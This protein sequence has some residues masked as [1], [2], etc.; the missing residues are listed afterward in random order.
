VIAC[1]CVIDVDVRYGTGDA[2]TFFRG[3]LRYE[4]FGC[5]WCNARARVCVFVFHPVIAGSMLMSCIQ[6]MGYL[7]DAPSPLFAPGAG[8][9]SVT[10]R[11]VTA[12][13]LPDFAGYDVEGATMRMLNIADTD[14]VCGGACEARIDSVLCSLHML[15]AQ[16]DGMFSACD[17][18]GSG[19]RDFTTH[20]LGLFSSTPVP[21]N[22]A[23]PLDA[24]CSLMLSKMVFAQVT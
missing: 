23:T 10:W 8:G 16:C 17:A 19:R 22:V 24:L 2:Q 20:R 12:S 11:D 15:S 9:T 14:Q 4:G 7:S 13:L 21:T 18:R 6:K 3:T 5:V 1:A